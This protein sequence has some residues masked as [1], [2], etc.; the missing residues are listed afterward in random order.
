MSDWNP[1][2]DDVSKNLGLD[3]ESLITTFTELGYSEKEAKHIIEWTMQA[4]NPIID[5][6]NLPREQV[7]KITGYQD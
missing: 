5:I 2:W 4:A 7:L 3:D 1:D 6:D